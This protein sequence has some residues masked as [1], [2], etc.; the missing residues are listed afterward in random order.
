MK[1]LDIIQI[2]IAVIG[3]IGG[4]LVIAGL[5]VRRIEDGKRK[6]RKAEV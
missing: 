6:N 1:V 2:G 4:I 3:G 5:I